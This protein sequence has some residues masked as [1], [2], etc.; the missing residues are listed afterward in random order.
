MVTCPID[1]YATATVV[2]SDGTGLVRGPRDCPK[3][4]RAV[5][6]TLERF[7][8]DALD[9]ALSLESPIP[10]GKGM[11]SS[12]ADVV[13]SVAA[14]AAALGR[15]PD[16]ELEAD[17]ALLVEPSD[18][19]MLPGIALFDHV[20]GRVR[21]CLGE[22]PPIDVLVLEF[23]AELDTVAFN[24][25]D[26]TAALRSRA[27]SFRESLSLIEAGI[28]S[29]DAELIGRGAS[30]SAT[31]YQDVL[32]KPELPQVFALADAAGA[33]G[34]NVA[35]SGTV[36]GMLF[37]EDAERLEWAAAQARSRLLGL[38]ATHRHRLIGGG[39][40]VRCRLLP[41]EVRC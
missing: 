31:T 22:P 40:E 28:T 23:E 35:H 2:L 34:V 20:S 37:N 19:T 16:A 27:D 7:G 1:L 18:G 26:R 9:A 4:V 21:R 29:A 36:V 8:V 13:A 15:P 25:I 10:R 17:I 11:A 32:A 30:L 38:R 41:D 3:A 14:T 12:T 24:A 39:S 5:A 6:L 33:T